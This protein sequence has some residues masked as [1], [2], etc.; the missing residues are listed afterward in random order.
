MKR[1]LK[2]IIIFSLSIILVFFS[3]LSVYAQVISST[4]TAASTTVTPIIPNIP[5]RFVV[6]L[7]ATLDQVVQ[8]LLDQ[9]YIKDI[10]DF[11]LVFSKM[12]GNILP[13][14][15]KITIGMTVKNIVTILHGEPYMKWVVIPPGLRKEEIAQ[16]LATTLG[17]TKLQENNWIN[18]YTKMKY[19]YIE[20]VYFPDTYL[21]P[22]NETPLAVA[23][24]LI[25]EFNENFAQYLPQF[26]SKNIQWTNGLILASIVQREAANDADMPLIAGILLNRL[27]QKIPLSVDATLQ[28]I[29]GNTGQGWWAP[30]TAA[31]KENNSPYNTY[32]KVGLPP[33]PISNPGLAAI[34][35]VLNPTQTACLYYLH[36]KNHI[37]HCAV[38]YSD[39]L[40]NIEKYLINPST[41]SQPA[42]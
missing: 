3:T 23:N 40:A 2:K 32:K 36:D 18:I 19:D 27:N 7:N 14:G 22:V 30:I 12:N 8:S 15:Y 28:Y 21:I 24:R 4:T 5:N 41:T 26:Q 16:L 33:H 34:E 35:A 29:R 10:N 37:T 6:P 11:T 38:T 17:W 9:N 13:G 31:D 25:S 20:G 39:H 1:T 42:Q